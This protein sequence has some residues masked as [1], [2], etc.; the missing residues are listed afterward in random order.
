LTS[1][2]QGRRVFALRVI[3]KQ[4]RKPLSPT[5]VESTCGC[6]WAA[7]RL[8]RYRASDPLEGGCFGSVLSAAGGCVDRSGVGSL[9]YIDAGWGIDVAGES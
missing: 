2:G 9:S 6:G 8:L 5:V 3:K 7:S 1:R 4:G